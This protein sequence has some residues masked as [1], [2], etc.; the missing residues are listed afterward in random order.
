M[1]SNKY[2]LIN[3]IDKCCC[4]CFETFNLIKR[5]RN[6]YYTRLNLKNS[7]QTDDNKNNE[8]NDEKDIDDLINK[9][10]NNFE[11]ENEENDNINKKNN[12]DE[13][14]IDEYTDNRIYE[15]T[16][17]IIA[18]NII[19]EITDNII[20]EIADNMIDEK[21]ELDDYLSLNDIEK[22]T[23]SNNIIPD[24][25]LV[26]SCCNK[27]YICIGCIRKIINNYE[28]H[29][30]NENNS[31]M[32]CPYPFEDCLTKIGFKNFFDHNLIYKICNTE[33]EWNNYL[34]H[35]N[36]Y[37]FPG[38]T[39]IKCPLNNYRINSK[40]NT[41]I[42]VENEILKTSNKGDLIIECSQNNLCLKKFCYYCH[43][44]IYNYYPIC[45][46]CKTNYENENPN[47][48]NYYFNKNYHIHNNKDISDEIS[49]N[50]EY[51][52]YTSSTIEDKMIYDESSYLFKNN[53]ITRE[54]AFKQMLML[55]ENINSF[56]I[57]PICKNSLYKTEKCNALSHHN[58]ERC[59]ACG[60][61][62]FQIKGLG[63]HWNVAGISGCYRFDHDTFIKNY[64]SEY[65]CNEYCSNHE[66]GDCTIY[67]HCSGI[68]L[69]EKIRIKSCVFHSINSLLPELRFVVYDDLY[70]FLNL[71]NPQLLELLPF[72]QTLVL[73]SVYKERSRDYYEQ[74][75]YEELN[76]KYPQTIEQFSLDKTFY[77]DAQMYLD[78][79]SLNKESIQN[80]NDS[81]SLI[82]YNDNNN[83]NNNIN[84]N[85]IDIN[86]ENSNFTDHIYR[87][88]M[89]IETDNFFINI[90]EISQEDI[91]TRLYVPQLTLQQSNIVIDYQ[92]N[93]IHD[94]ES[95]NNEIQHN[96]IQH[97]E[98]HNNEIHNNENNINENNESDINRDDVTDEIIIYNR[99]SIRRELN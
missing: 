35:S 69:L 27:H 44:I 77:I 91:S 2:K 79:Y 21:I 86:F 64:V 26:R 93:E 3:D 56:M 46:T 25:L 17:D 95:Q 42:L 94:N 80:S 73:L 53:E 96:E 48:Y 51:T 34:E 22:N 55:L 33:D 71:N 61:I 8:Q 92:H 24:D 98:I 31:H 5:T 7:E 29:P 50:S 16:D 97:N 49:E 68:K 41:D 14:I 87:S 62:G 89:N 19:N 72:K 88:L 84:T 67:E 4:V 11:E 28:N 15:Y 81:G 32:A 65:V 75:I 70:D 76:C 12:L 90:N 58:L 20:D 82:I 45:Y 85:L 52:E 18:D 39:I 9:Y 10:I 74:I 78:N 37:A 47:V 66:K 54:I 99:N 6:Y 40:C 23:F 57:C 83:I 30:I 60:R 38:Y 63:D 13:Y 36:R 43:E 1:I 59:Y